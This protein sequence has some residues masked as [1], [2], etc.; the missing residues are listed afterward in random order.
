MRAYQAIMWNWTR[1]IEEGDES[2]GDH[3]CDFFSGPASGLLR[4]GRTKVLSW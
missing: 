4:S 1:Q 2:W 3:V